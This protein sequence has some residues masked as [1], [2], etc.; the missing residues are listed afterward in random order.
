[1]HELHAERQ[2]HAQD[3]LRLA[4][5][6]D[7][8]GGNDRLAGLDAAVLAGEA[9]LLGVGVLALQA[10]LGPGGVDQLDLLVRGL[11]APAARSASGRR[12]A[13]WAAG[14]GAAAGAF[15]AA[16]GAA[17]ALRGAGAGAGAWACTAEATSVAA[18]AVAANR[19]KNR[20]RGRTDAAKIRKFIA[21]NPF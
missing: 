21:E 20:P 7:D 10:E 14:A 1:M 19:A 2:R 8:D 9:D 3:L 12:R 13:C 5:G 15:G 11:A 16:F 6:L 4:F 18:S 17:L